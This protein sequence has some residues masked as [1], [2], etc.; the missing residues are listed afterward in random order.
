MKK[1]NGV[2]EGGPPSSS[3][4]RELLQQYFGYDRF[5][6]LQEEITSHVLAKQDAFVL[7]PTGGGKSLCYQL[8]AL[9][10]PGMTLVISPLIAL[11]KDQVDGLRESG[12]EAAFLNSSISFDVAQEIQ[13]EVEQGHVKLLYVAPE[14]IAQPWFQQWLRRLSISLVAVD[15][16]HCI[17]AWGHD[18]RPEY[19]QLALLRTLLPRVPFIALTATAN[20]QVRRDII[21]QLQLEQGKVFCS[22]F[23]RPNLTYEVRP[24]RQSF[25]QLVALL[26]AHRG[27][28]IVIY[29]VSRKDTERLAEGLQKEGFSAA[30]YHAGLASEIRARVQDRFLRDDVQVIVDTIAFGM[31]IDKP[32]VRLVVHMDLPK[33]VEGYYQET[34][35]AGR[36][37][38]PSACVLF[39]SPGDRFKQ[40]YFIDQLTKEEERDRARRQ[41][42]DMIRYSETNACRRAYLLKYFGE[43]WEQVNCSGCDR[44]LAPVVTKEERDYTEEIKI[45][46]RIVEAL[47]GNYG[48]EQVLAIARGANVKK[49]RERNHHQLA[50]YGALSKHTDVELKHLIREGLERGW[51]VK[52]GDRYP[53]LALGKDVPA[54][55]EKGERC[56]LAAFIAEPTFAPTRPTRVAASEELGSFDHV[57]F[58]RLRVL[59]RRLADE[60]KVPAYIIFGDRTLQECARRR[61]TTKEAFATVP[62]VGQAKLVAFGEIFV[63]EI[64]NALTEAKG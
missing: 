8:P 53:L 49:V 43:V 11:M 2:E 24:K 16:A 47:Q 63:T 45:L 21:A 56:A 55:L 15:E 23:N 3:M 31:G 58:E 39:Y 20:E 29:C 33:S 37:G 64:K 32:N 46:V 30:A 22:S 6:P 25:P 5:R 17:S 61:P 1:G 14:R 40:D 13:R 54:R 34:G 12:I 38:L 36:D 62:G 9:A 42:M 44:C 10:F 4:L 52:Q 51:F 18:F 41:L 28:S 19:R 50:D 48:T 59:R 60:R 27:S 7:M 57:L 35:R 26:E